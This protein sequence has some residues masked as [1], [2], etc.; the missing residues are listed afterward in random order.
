MSETITVPKMPETIEEFVAFRDEVA[1]T[2][3]GGAA[4]MVVAM[5]AYTENEELGRQCLTVAADRGRLQE[6]MNGYKGWQLLNPELQRLK[7]RILGKGHIP[8]SYVQ[9]TGPESG[10]ALPDGPLE[11]L[12]STNPHSGDMSTGSYKVFVSSTGADSPRPIALK[13]NN[14]G[15]WKG[16]EWS[17]LTLGV[18]PPKQVV[19]D[20]L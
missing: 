4:V 14:K 5:I 17:S 20:D 9:G 8:R 7:G 18:V 16:H 1:S 19:D 10:Y 3:E 13:R 15:L 6:G 11:I 12:V 2:P